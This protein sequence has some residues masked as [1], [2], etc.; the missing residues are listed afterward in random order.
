MSAYDSSFQ[1]PL[2]VIQ[3]R[4]LSAAPNACIKIKINDYNFTSCGLLCFKVKQ[5][6]FMNNNPVTKVRLILKISLF[7]V[8]SHLI[9]YNY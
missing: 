4:S 8:E 2:I 7:S 9:N 5:L 1:K 6:E 3:V